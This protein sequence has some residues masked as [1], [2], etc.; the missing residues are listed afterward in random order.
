M[1]S[2]LI[3]SPSHSYLSGRRGMLFLHQIPFRNFDI[4]RSHSRHPPPPPIPTSTTRL[5]FWRE[6]FFQH[7][8][9][10]RLRVF[11]SIA[12]KQRVQYLLPSRLTR[13]GWIFIAA[14]KFSERAR[15]STPTAE[16]RIRKEDAKG[17]CAGGS[18]PASHWSTTSQVL[19][20]ARPGGARE[21]TKV[22][23]QGL[24]LASGPFRYFASR[25]VAFDESRR[26]YAFLPMETFHRTV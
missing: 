16:S 13:V 1:P 20:M 11:F 22:A 15:T 4:L 21:K 7:S 5:D 6:A 23:A 26:F 19:K 14:H 12:K 3:F 25:C 2:M 8:I 24:V 9:P 17:W 18:S 10:P